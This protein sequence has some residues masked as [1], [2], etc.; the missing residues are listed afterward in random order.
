MAGIAD[1]MVKPIRIID[2]V[3]DWMVHNTPQHQRV[4]TIR[5]QKAM[6]RINKWYEDTGFKVSMEK[7]KTIVFNRRTFTITTRPRM[8]AWAKREK[9]KQVRQHRILGLH[10]TL[11]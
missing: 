10:L 7:T 3:D 5:I 2:N 1:G 6:D 8:N 11:G 9:I 4:A